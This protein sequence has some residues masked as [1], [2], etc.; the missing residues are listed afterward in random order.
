MCAL[1]IGKD[2]AVP[3]HFVRAFGGEEVV[4]VILNVDT[5]CRC[6][7]RVPTQEGVCVGPTTGLDPLERQHILPLP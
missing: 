2:N 5:L 3:V 7:T 6:V 1:S 4:F